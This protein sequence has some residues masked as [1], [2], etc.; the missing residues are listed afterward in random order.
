MKYCAQDEKIAYLCPR[1]EDYIRKMS[2]YSLGIPFKITCGGEAASQFYNPLQER[3]SSDKRARLDGIT[4]ANVA[5]TLL[6][7]IV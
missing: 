6:K 7:M 4:T 5:R 1:I 2:V 3:V